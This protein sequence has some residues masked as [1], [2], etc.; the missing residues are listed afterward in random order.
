M[1]ILA[2][3]ITGKMPVPRSEFAGSRNVP[4]PPRSAPHTSPYRLSAV[5]GERVNE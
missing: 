3:T 5:S 1:A 4:C 2:M